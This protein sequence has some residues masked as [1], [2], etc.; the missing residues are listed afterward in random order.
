MDLR[1]ENHTVLGEQQPRWKAHTLEHLSPFLPSAERD[2][3]AA[4]P[5]TL[6]QHKP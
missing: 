4:A 5:P 3:V 6:W 2:D 1:G